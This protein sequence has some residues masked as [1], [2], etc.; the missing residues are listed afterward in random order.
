MKG[1][2]QSR[3]RY[4]DR[5]IMGDSPEQ[6]VFAT[7]LQTFQ[8]PHLGWFATVAGR[9]CMLY[10]WNGELWFRAGNGPPIPLTD[11]AVTW[12]RQAD[13]AVFSIAHGS[14]VRFTETH[15]VCD[16][17]LGIQNDPTPF[18]EAEDFDFFLFVRNIIN[19]ESRSTRIGRD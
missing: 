16:D 3:D 14:D 15:R 13:V 19:D 6:M 11:A 7:A 10:R 8:L 5:M 4:A 1:Y 17:V 12:D 18:V 9:L 2:L